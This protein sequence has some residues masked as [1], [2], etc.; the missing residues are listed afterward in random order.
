M[1]AIAII[2][3]MLGALSLGCGASYAAEPCRRGDGCRGEIPVRPGLVMPVYALWPLHRTKPE[4]TRL[5]IV[6]HGSTRKAGRY[7]RRM[8]RAAREVGEEDGSQVIVPHFRVRG[9]DATEGDRVAFWDRNADWKRGD[10]SALFPGGGLGSFEALDLMRRWL[11]RKRL[12][13]NLSRVVIA[14]HSAGGQFVQRYA[15]GSPAA[16]EGAA[17]PV[18][19]VIANPSSY[20]YFDTRRPDGREGFTLARGSIRCPVN[21]YKYGPEGRNDFM[22][23]EPLAAMV[24]RYRRRDVVYLL[25]EA[26]NDPSARNL[27]RRCPAAAQGPH[28]LARGKWFKAYMDRFFAPHGH[29]LVLVPGVAHS[30]NRMFRSPQGK[31]VVFSD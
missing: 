29:R 2:L 23:G 20:M 31:A 9:D 10:E 26:D 21:A 28:R 13:P 19:Y 8:A 27:D 16:P 1:R 5:V 3:F 22:A 11:A 12:Y 17:I 7:F 6:I 4:I 18:R 24:Q 15:L 14:G 30:S 25:G